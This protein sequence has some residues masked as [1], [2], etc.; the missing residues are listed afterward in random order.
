MIFLEVVFSYFENVDD[1]TLQKVM[2]LVILKSNYTGKN[3]HFQKTVN[4]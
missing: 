2:F 4:A 3:L 1:F